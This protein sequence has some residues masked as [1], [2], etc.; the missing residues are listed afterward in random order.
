[1][2]EG[3]VAPGDNSISWNGSNGADQFH[4]GVYFWTLTLFDESG[5][6]SDSASGPITVAVEPKITSTTNAGVDDFAW[7]RNWGNSYYPDF[8]ISTPLVNAAGF[9][10]NMSRSPIFVD[11]SGAYDRMVRIQG[12]HFGG[13]MDLPGI[14]GLVMPGST[15]SLEGLWYPTFRSYTVEPASLAHEY[16]PV[17]WVWRVGYDETSPSAPTG[18]AVASGTSGSFDPSGA[19]VSSTRRLRLKWDWNDYD[20]LSGTAYFRVYV[21]NA[22]RIPSAANPTSGENTQGVPWFGAG[23]MPSLTI[24]DL[25]PGHHLIQMTAVDRATNE[26]PRSNTV[27]VWID[28]DMPTIAISAPS[29]NIVGKSMTIAATPADQGGVSSVVFKIDG[30]TVATDVTSP[31]SAT[32]DMTPFGSGAHT[33]T[34]TVTDMYGRTATTTKTIT[35]DIT[36]PALSIV[37]KGPSPFYPKKR[38]GYR[39]DYIIK[40]ASSEAATAKLVFKTSKGTTFKTINTNVSSGTSSIKWNGKSGGGKFKEGTYSW[41]LYLT[42]AAGNTSVTKS[43]KATERFYQLKK[44]SKSKVKLVLR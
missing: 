4:E 27:S 21:D 16:S 22:L 38:N 40:L 7:R 12:T 17:T 24:E 2:L 33:I 13:T 28:P 8:E 34:A 14:A 1:M 44:V 6:F 5:V 23:G 9:L 43:G 37:S 11:V 29:T 39:D 25:E 10:Y 18:V 41:T 35:C 31:Y 32:I 26:G 30:K 36:S 3:T 19:F 20:V 42:D 15:R